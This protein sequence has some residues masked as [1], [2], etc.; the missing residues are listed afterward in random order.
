MAVEGQVLLTLE[1]ANLLIAIDLVVASIFLS[2]TEVYSTATR[3]APAK[4]L[5]Y[6]IA[7]EHIIIWKL[8]F[9]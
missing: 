8:S 9:S 4:E 3:A 1:K 2:A 6:I 5:A 7:V